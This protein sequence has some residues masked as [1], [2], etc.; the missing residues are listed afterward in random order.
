MHTY[1]NAYRYSFELLGFAVA[2][3]DATEDELNEG[4]PEAT[5]TTDEDSESKVI[6]YTCITFSDVELY[7]V[8][9]QRMKIF[10]EHEE[11]YCDILK[12]GC[13]ERLLFCFCGLMG[14]FFLFA[15]GN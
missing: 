1:I 3:E 10:H 14:I 6:Y 7:K 12:I 13:I 11:I 15:G 9:I 5:A 2:V 8:T 4:D